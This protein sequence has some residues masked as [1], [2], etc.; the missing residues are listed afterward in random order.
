M[1]DEI[2]PAARTLFFNRLRRE[3]RYQK[4]LA[5]L[6]ER[7][8]GFENKVAWN[9]IAPTVM[10]E[11]GYEGPKKEREI[12]ATYLASKHKGLLAEQLRAEKEEIRKER[13][14]ENYEDA[15][16]G[17]PNRASSAVEMEW[18]RAHPAVSRLDRQKDQ[19]KQVILTAE[20]VLLPPH[21]PAPSKY[22]VQALQHWVNRPGKFFEQMLSEDKKAMVESEV[23]A[24]EVIDDL[25]E[26]EQLLLSVRQADAEPEDSDD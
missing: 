18:I 20:D 5:V 7:S 25:T 2:K 3:G 4:Y 23:A 24:S 11:F 17:L 13:V 21:G 26:V 6:R 1:S 8:G 19:T 15:L 16:R 22:A 10:K 14:V 12:H 9:K